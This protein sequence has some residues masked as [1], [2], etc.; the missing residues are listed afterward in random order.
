MKEKNFNQ[1][2]KQNFNNAY[3]EINEKNFKA[4]KNIYYIPICREK[5]CGGNLNI[6]FDKQNFLA[7]YTCEKNKEHCNA[8]NLYLL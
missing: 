5:G 8:Y 2:K 7:H 1:K 6:S 3:E 4:K